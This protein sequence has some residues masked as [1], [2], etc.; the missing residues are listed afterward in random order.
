MRFNELISGVRS[1][2][3][4]KIFGDDLD[5]LLS[6]AGKVQAVLQKVPGAADVKSEQVTGL[7]VLTV[8]PNRVALARYGVSVAELQEVVEI[9]VGG[10][11]AGLVFE[12]DRRFDVVMR[13]PEHQ[14]ADLDAIS[15]LPVPVPPPAK[16]LS[17][18][19]PAH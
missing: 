2:L 7:P 17:G 3:G 11:T 16:P 12:G 8:K 5:T 15:S 9:A 4:I 14:R 10:K 6:V 1:D 13:L 19:R 18:R